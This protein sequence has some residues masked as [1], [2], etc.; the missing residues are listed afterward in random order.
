VNLN[1]FLILSLFAAYTG[2]ATVARSGPPPGCIKMECAEIF[3]GLRPLD[4]NG[5]D[6]N[7]GI[8]N[9][10]DGAPLIP[11]DKDGVQDEDGIPDPDPPPEAKE[12]LAV[13]DAG[14]KTKAG[15]G[16]KVSDLDK[17]GFP[18]AYDQCINEAEDFDGFEDND[19]CPEPDNDGDG[20]LDK[21]DPCPNIPGTWCTADKT[22]PVQAAAAA[23]PTPTSGNKETLEIKD[24]IIFSAGSAKL[25][26]GKSSKALKALVAAL[27]DRPEVKLEIRGHTDNSIKEDISKKLSLARANAVRGYLVRM[28]IAADRLSTVGMG[29]SEPLVPND[30]ADNRAKNRRVEFVVVQ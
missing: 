21:D 2:C 25:D 27:K 8:K 29:S 1:R 11:E 19:G 18:D 16:Q 5:D 3:E 9:D 24:E 4:P 28:K 10:V 15:K 13:A 22:K 26:I 23:A 30:S 6:D 20:T 14:G 17:D 7:D 12:D